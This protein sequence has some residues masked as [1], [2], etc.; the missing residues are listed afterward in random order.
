MPHTDR[1][2][3][4]TNWLIVIPTKPRAR[5]DK[6]YSLPTA[7]QQTDMM[8]IIEPVND[9]IHTSLVDKSVPP[10]EVSDEMGFSFI[11]GNDEIDEVENDESDEEGKW[12]DGNETDEAPEN[13]HLYDDDDDDSGI[14]DDEDADD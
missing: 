14:D 7:Y 5:V 3:N 12:D 10:E 1:S 2:R 11:Q 9:A 6:Q 4:R 8:T 13:L